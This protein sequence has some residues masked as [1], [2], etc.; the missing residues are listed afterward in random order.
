MHGLPRD[1]DE[2]LRLYEETIRTALGCDERHAWIVAHHLWCRGALAKFKP[3]EVLTC[4]EAIAYLGIAPATWKVTARRRW[5]ILPVPVEGSYAQQASRYRFVDVDR[6]FAHRDLVF[7]RTAK[8]GFRDPVVP[9]LGEFIAAESRKVAED[10][11]AGHVFDIPLHLPQNPTQLERACSNTVAKVI[12]YRLK[13][14]LAVEDAVNDIWVKILNSNIVMKFIRS[15]PK[16]LPPLLSTDDALDFLGVEWSDWQNMMEQYPAAPN[17]VKGASSS[18]D[19]VYRTEDIRALDE[20]GYFQTRS[21]RILPAACVGPGSFERYLQRAVEHALKNIFRTLDRRFNREDT[22]GEGACIQENRR[23]RRLDRDSF[24]VAWE[25]TLSEDDVPMES[26]VDIAR[27]ARLKY[28][29]EF[30]AQAEVNAEC[31]TER[32]TTDQVVGVSQTA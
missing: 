24:D 8:V 31:S 9:G 28:P 17:P 32:A 13:Y 27:R 4:D 1:V 30:G 11:A 5:E 16:R 3:P 2:L 14:G 21:V 19:A 12:R 29:E 22:L 25:D 10:M 26:F 20:S 15:A 6:L 7:T 23:V 18:P